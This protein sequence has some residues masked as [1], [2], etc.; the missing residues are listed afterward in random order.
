VTFIEEGNCSF[1]VN[2]NFIL[3]FD[4]VW[5]IRYFGESDEVIILPSVRKLSGGCFAYCRTVSSVIF[6]CASKL[7]CIERSAF[8]G[9]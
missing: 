3:D 8:C 6:E 9:C 1:T 4:G 7:S 2:G 5:I